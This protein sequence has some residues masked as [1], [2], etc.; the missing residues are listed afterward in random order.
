MVD[1]PN[2]STEYQSEGAAANPSDT[3]DRRF[4]EAAHNGGE[5][6]AEGDDDL[7]PPQPG[8]PERDRDAG[9]S[10]VPGRSDRRGGRTPEE[11]PRAHMPAG[12]PAPEGSTGDA[13]EGAD[14]LATAGVSVA[15][16]DPEQGA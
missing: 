10:S 2:L 14:D 9:P 16:P 11:D 6:P 15:P 1:R 13:T 4:A 3:L 12:S 8:S 7:P 5:A